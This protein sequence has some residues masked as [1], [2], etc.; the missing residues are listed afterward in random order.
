MAEYFITKREKCKV[1]DGTGRKAFIEKNSLAI[2]S[3]SLTPFHPQTTITCGH[4]VKGYIETQVDLL[5][6][7]AKVRWTDINLQ[8]TAL[9]P[10]S[11]ARNTVHISED[12]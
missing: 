11:M 9:I 8:H 4:C 5:E 10:T 3:S 6:V 12:E 7:L 1:C 2:N